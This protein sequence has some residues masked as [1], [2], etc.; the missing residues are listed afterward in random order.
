V[1]RFVVHHL[2]SAFEGDR[3]STRD[4]KTAALV[5]LSLVPL[6]A[7]TAASPTMTAPISSREADL[8]WLLAIWNDRKESELV[9]AFA[10]TTAAKLAADAPAKAQ[11]AWKAVLCDTLK[12]GGSSS[13][14]LEQSA[15]LALGALGDNDDDEPDHA[16]APCCS[17]RRRAA[18]G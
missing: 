9:R 11:E 10:A 6:A 17:A 13:A 12:P 8:D 14:V 15:A 5:G 2:V 18:R 3:S 1:R 7:A 4:V 16:S